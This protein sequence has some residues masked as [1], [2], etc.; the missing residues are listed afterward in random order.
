VVNYTVIAAVINFALFALIAFVIGGDAVNGKREGGR[1]YLALRSQY[2]EVS[3]WLYWYSFIHVIFVFC[4]HIA[5]IVIGLAYTD[6]G[7]RGAGNR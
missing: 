1:Y 2:T 3:A 5:A 6:F 4:T 7:P